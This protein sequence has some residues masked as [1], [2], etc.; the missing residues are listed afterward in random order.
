MGWRGGEDS[1]RCFELDRGILALMD[2]FGEREVARK[3]ESANFN[4]AVF[5]ALSF[6]I[7]DPQIR[8]GMLGRGVAIKDA[9]TAL[10]ADP[11]FANAVESDTAGVPNTFTRLQS[12]GQ[13]LRGITGLQ[14]RLPELEGGR[15]RFNGFW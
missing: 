5:D 13:T 6:Y 4:R 2:I 1:R 8:G 7:C 9:Y 14:F 12:W 3:P 10:F 15:I 11:A